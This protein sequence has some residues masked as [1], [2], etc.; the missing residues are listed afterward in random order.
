MDVK[1]VQKNDH[2]DAKVALAFTQ[3]EERSLGYC[4]S[5]SMACDLTKKLIYEIEDCM[6]AVSLDSDITKSR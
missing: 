1:E 2:G 4:E 5:C 6:Q 3:T